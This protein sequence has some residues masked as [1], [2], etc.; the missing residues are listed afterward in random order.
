MVQDLSTY[1]LD[2][3]TYQCGYSGT[4]WLQAGA[5]GWQLTYHLH[6][7]VLDLG[8][9]REMAVALLLGVMNGWHP[10][11]SYQVDFVRLEGSKPVTV[12]LWNFANIL[13]VPKRTLGKKH[14]LVFNNQD[15]V[16]QRPCGDNTKRSQYSTMVWIWVENQVTMNWNPG[17]SACDWHVI[18]KYTEE[19]EG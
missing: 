14:T 18:L 19:T 12:G 3:S 15:S 7:L 6:R 9:V 13:C 8:V 2:L 10:W 5:V 16:V 4:F 1:L 17:L 11:S